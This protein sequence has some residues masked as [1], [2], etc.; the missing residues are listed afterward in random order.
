[1]AAVHQ[2]ELYHEIFGS[3]LD[4][5]EMTPY[6]LKDSSGYSESIR[7]ATL[8]MAN[9]GF[10][11]MNGEFC[12][13]EKERAAEIVRQALRY[14]SLW[15]LPFVKKQMLDLSRIDSPLRDVYLQSIDS[16]IRIQSILNDR[17]FSTLVGE[18]PR[19]LFLLSSSVKYQDLFRGYRG[20]EL[21]VSKDWQRMGCSI[22]KMC[23]LIKSIEEDSQDINDYA[24]LGMSLES[25]GI[26]L[27]NLFS[28][29]WD[30]SAFIPD[31]EP[32]RLAFVKIAAFFRKIRESMFFDKIRNCD[33]FDS[34]DGVRVDIVGVKARLKSPE[35]MFT[36][37]GKSIEGEAYDIRD[38]LAVT[39][40]LREREDALTLFHALQKRGVIL[41]ENTAS[42]SI[43]QTLFDTPDDMKEAVRRLMS[44]VALSADE[45]FQL[46][47]NEICEN[48]VSF[49]RALNVNTQVNQYS[50]G[51]HRKFQCKINY[52]VP[53]HRSA[54]DKAILVPGSEA[55]LKRSA[56]NIVTRQYTLPVELR[57]SD[58]R[59]WEE[60]EWK[61]EAHHDAYKF[62]QLLALMN[63]LFDPVFSFP[64]DHFTALRNDQSK[65]F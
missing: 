25:R 18:D 64:A 34:G 63:R 30:N 26:S 28:L 37:L 59:S 4:R 31:D 20:S 53:V 29:N 42:T 38:I 13:G 16:I 3:I 62:R 58:F 56:K 41:Q 35:S 65:I 39:F 51:G 50:S 33:V 22:L 23:H 47:E 27:T 11:V 21:A 40:L 36:K 15:L 8:M 6:L 55:Y 24:R 54:D 48:S 43:T 45:S 1:M 12:P 44:F 17:A 2:Q 14:F 5:R 46:S 9:R 60:S 52:S 19:H 57:I 32:A 61:G 10:D 49:F 7:Q